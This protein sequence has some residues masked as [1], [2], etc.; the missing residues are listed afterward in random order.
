MITV[1]LIGPIP[2]CQGYIAV[3]IIVNWFTKAVKYEATHLE[4]NSE[5]FARIIRDRVIRNHGL[6]HR[7]IHDRDTRFMSKYMKELFTIL[8][9]KQNPSTAYHPQTDGQTE[10]MDQNV[11]RYLRAFI[12]YHQDDWK[13]WLSAAEFSYNDSVHAATQQTP[14]FLNYGQHPWKGEDTRQ[15]VRNESAAEFADRMKKVRLDAKA[16]LEQ[17]AQ[18][19]KWSYDKHA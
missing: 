14:F 4:L 8:G 17:A 7:I 11:E 2:E 5:G 16:A 3:L 18:K 13:E 9:T 10:R 12:N 19:M 1:D 6:P 15:E